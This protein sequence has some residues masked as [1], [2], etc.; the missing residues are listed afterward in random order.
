MRWAASVAWSRWGSCRNRPCGRQPLRSPT[1]WRGAAFWHL[2]T[3]QA[4]E[5]IPIQINYDGA[6]TR[7]FACAHSF[8][9]MHALVCSH[10][11]SHAVPTYGAADELREL[12]RQ[13]A[14]EDA[15]DERWHGVPSALAEQSASR[16]LRLVQVGCSRSSAERG[17]RAPG[18]ARHDRFGV[19]SGFFGRV[20]V[21]AL[22]VERMCSEVGAQAHQGKWRRQH[23]VKW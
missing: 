9:R 8:V 20:V 19:A 11:C 23:D 21:P 15:L 18:S 4:G 6:R 17:E 2:R 16:A 22:W 3:L 14:T 1:T 12:R 5:P 7:L 13:S 10:A